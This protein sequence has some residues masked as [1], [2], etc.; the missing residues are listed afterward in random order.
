ML[1]ALLGVYYSISFRFMLF[2]RFVLRLKAYGLFCLSLVY[3]WKRLRAEGW[4][5]R[6]HDNGCGINEGNKQ[7]GRQKWQQKKKLRRKL[8]RSWRNDVAQPDCEA[9][10]TT[11]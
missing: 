6:W 11:G 3:F 7:S 5:F 2:V 10:K 8:S 4:V 1:I 9:S